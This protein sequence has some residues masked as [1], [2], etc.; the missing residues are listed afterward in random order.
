MKKRLNMLSQQ[1]VSLLRTAENCLKLL[2]TAENHYVSIIKVASNEKM[3]HFFV[4]AKSQLAE[5]C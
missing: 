5:N 3:L 4:S 2:R 1:N